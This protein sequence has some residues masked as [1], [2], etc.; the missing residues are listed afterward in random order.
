MALSFLGNPE[1]TVGQNFDTVPTTASEALAHARACLTGP[2]AVKVSGSA[3]DHGAKGTQ[4]RAFWHSMGQGPRRLPSQGRARLILARGI[5]QF[6]Q[7]LAVIIA[8]SPLRPKNDLKT[9]P[10]PRWN[11]RETYFSG[12]ICGAPG[13]WGVLP[14]W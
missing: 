6:Y 2:V 7:W 13:P 14:I 10:K 1:A 8:K 4:P 11:G 3:R 9:A 5:Y 12:R